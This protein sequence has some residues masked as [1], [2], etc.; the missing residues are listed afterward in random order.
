ML[1]KNNRISIQKTNLVSS[2]NSFKYLSS[3]KKER[4]S[5]NLARKYDDT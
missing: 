5:L 4:K 1:L 2:Q 3:R